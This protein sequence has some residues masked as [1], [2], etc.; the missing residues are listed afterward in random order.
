MVESRG[1]G[2]EANMSVQTQTEIRQDE[3]TG[4]PVDISVLIPITER[5]DDIGEVHREY[6]EAI[7]GM[8]MDYEMIFI[9]DGHY[10]EAYEKLKE[11]KS[12]GERLKIIKHARGFGE[13]EA[14]ATGFRHARGKMILTLPAYRQVGIAKLHR[15]F[16]AIRDC[17]MVVVRRWPRSDSLF[18]KLQ[19]RM[20]RSVVHAITGTVASDIGC[21]V[22]LIKR[23]VIEEISLYGDL[24]RFLPILASRQ[25]FH[26]R[27][28]DLPQAASEKRVRVYSAGVYLRRMI[29]LL[30][31]FF[32]VKFTKKPLRFFGLTGFAVLSVGVVISLYLVLERL[33]FQVAL[34]NR[35]LFLIGILFVVLGLQIFAIGLVGELLIF[36]HARELKDYAIEEVIN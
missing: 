21:G 32:L 23:K 16:D 1:A 11:L 2:D 26:V 6:R 36:T 10:P 25:G 28:T 3:P 30:T 20:F 22:R 34:S 17:D 24:H 14:L 8:K 7:E 35:P 9:I 27:E 4:Q 13:A 15:L 19:T 31:V 33:L 29:D 12:R 5:H 18:N